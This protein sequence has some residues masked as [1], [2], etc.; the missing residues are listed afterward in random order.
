MKI[1]SF[2]KIKNYV[3]L[4]I[5]ALV[6]IPFL[7]SCSASE[8]QEN[9][10]NM[11]NSAAIN[12]VDDSDDIAGEDP[13]SVIENAQN[14]QSINEDK[15]VDSMSS[16]VTVDKQNDGNVTIVLPKEFFSEAGKSFDYEEYAEKQNFLSAVQNSDKSVNVV[17]TEA[18]HEELLRSIKIEIE[19]NAK[20]MITADA[21]PYIKNI[22]FDEDFQNI[23]IYVIKEEF[24]NTAVD[25]APFTL[26]ASAMIYQTY[27]GAEKFTKVNIF[28]EKTGEFLTSTVYPQ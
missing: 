20:K 10:G 25:F 7:F 6:L 9:P 12:Q 14:N 17:M 3:I 1:P 28:D 27:A 5:I 15:V 2:K 16:I 11:V 18:R 26:A 8:T 4:S 23:D 22:I 19:A 21:T 24:E 13:N